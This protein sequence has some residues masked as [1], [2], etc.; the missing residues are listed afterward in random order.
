MRHLICRLRDGS[1][2]FVLA[3]SAEALDWLSSG[4]SNVKGGRRISTTGPV[5]EKTQTRARTHARDPLIDHTSGRLCHAAVAC[6]HAA[7]PLLSHCRCR[8]RV[9]RGLRKL[10]KL[11]TNACSAIHTLMPHTHVRATF[12][13]LVGAHGITQFPPALFLRWT[14]C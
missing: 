1:G 13:M 2:G 8:T 14:T 9:L 4:A 5:A 6:R 12:R 7:T 10:R 3:T 11:K